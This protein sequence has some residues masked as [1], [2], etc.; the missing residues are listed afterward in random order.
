MGLV[1]DLAVGEDVEETEDGIVEDKTVDY[2]SHDGTR[3]ALEVRVPPKVEL[4]RHAEVVDR[5]EAW[6]YSTCLVPFLLAHFFYLA[7][8]FVKILEYMINRNFGYSNKSN[9]N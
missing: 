8:C 7:A 6:L 1:I 2:E 5:V 3:H 4:D 9:Q